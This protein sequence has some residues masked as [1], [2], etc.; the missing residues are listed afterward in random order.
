MV[1][2]IESTSLK[3]HLVSGIKDYLPPVPM[4]LYQGVGRALGLTSLT[5][6]RCLPGASSN[7]LS[8]LDASLY[9]VSM[10]PC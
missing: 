4:K 1:D 10:N 2:M 3:V 7:Q 9:V 8:R 6:F 5:A